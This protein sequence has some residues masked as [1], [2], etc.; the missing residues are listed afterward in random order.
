MS[1]WI[2]AFNTNDLMKQNHSQIPCKDDLFDFRWIE[3]EGQQNADEVQS[4]EENNQLN[5]EEANYQCHVCK[6]QVAGKY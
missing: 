1:A 2:L 4:N 6:A 3:E 5:A